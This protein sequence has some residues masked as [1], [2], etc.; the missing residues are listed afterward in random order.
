MNARAGFSRILFRLA[1]WLRLLPVFLMRPQDLISFTRS[2]YSSPTHVNG[3]TAPQLVDRGLNYDEAHLLGQIPVQTGRLLLLGGGGGREAI[4]MAQ[5]GFE[6]TAVDFVPEMVP[7]LHANARRHNVAIDCLV[8]DISRLD[9]P[10]ASFDVIWFSTALYSSIP[11]RALRISMLRRIHRALRPQ[12]CA[13][14]QFNWNPSGTYSPRVQRIGALVAVLTFGNR[15]FE[16][17]DQLHADREFIHSFRNE[18]DL[19]SEFEAAAFSVHYLKLREEFSMGA[20]IL[21]KG[22]A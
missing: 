4:P 6:V 1:R 14:C 15:Q 3:W 16:E 22:S 7:R 9:V 19:R 11:T 5:K 2:L 13:V 8:Q 10:Q 18:N 12:G 20:A 17:G 21:V